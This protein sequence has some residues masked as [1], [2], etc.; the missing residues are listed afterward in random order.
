MRQENKRALTAEEV[1]RYLQSLYGWVQEGKYITRRFY[2]DDWQDIT[3]FMKHLANSIEETN[4]HP[5]VILHTGTKTITVSTT[6]HSEGGLTMA[7]IELAKKLN[8][9]RPIKSK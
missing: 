1:N 8:E 9:Y 4:H 2:F 5:D 7:D 6:T 3:G